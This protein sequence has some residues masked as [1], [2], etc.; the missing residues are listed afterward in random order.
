MTRESERKERTLPSRPAT[1]DDPDER[2]DTTN[3]LDLALP[4]R[5]DAH[6]DHQDD[7]DS[8]RTDEHGDHGGGDSDAVHEASTPGKLEVP[9][10]GGV[11]RAADDGKEDAAPHRPKP[12]HNALLTLAKTL[13]WIAIAPA[14]FILP[15][16]LVLR[17][18]VIAYQANTYSGWEAIGIGAV[19][20]AVVACVVIAAFMYSFAIRPRYFLLLFN[21]WLT[22]MLC[23]GGYAMFQLAS[24]N[25]KT[26]EVRAYYTSLHPLLRLTVKNLTLMDKSLVITD[27]HRTR[28]EYR[29]MGIPPREYSLHFR[30]PT[31][32]VHAVDIR[33]NGRSKAENLLVELYFMVM[34]FETLRHVGTAD[35]LHVALPPGDTAPGD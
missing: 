8:D 7:H 16:L 13:A 14:V 17:V 26:E 1:D 4:G 3:V 34:G 9:A 6:E 31:G 19:A 5:T 22:A 24:A 20:S 35:H 27:V 11:E 25:A 15:I 28:E 23:Y 18:S 32:Y 12:R 30:Q 33:T 29:S 21:V 2:T 10:R